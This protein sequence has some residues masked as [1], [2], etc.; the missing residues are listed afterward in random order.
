MR[1]KA[2]AANLCAA[3]KEAVRASSP[4]QL[5]QRWLAESNA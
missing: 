4:N 3:S 2:Q 5:L 1:A